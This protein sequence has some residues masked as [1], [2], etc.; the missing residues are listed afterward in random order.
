MTFSK[1]YKSWEETQTRHLGWKE[2]GKVKNY[3]D[4]WSPHILELVEADAGV[5][6]YNGG[7]ET[8]DPGPGANGGHTNGG[9]SSPCGKGGYPTGVLGLWMEPVSQ[10][11]VSLNEVGETQDK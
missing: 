2:E 7:L 10:R 9:Y 4:Y 1:V 3:W 6:G 8:R 11:Q 5:L